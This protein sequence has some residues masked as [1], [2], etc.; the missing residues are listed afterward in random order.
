M[1]ANEGSEGSLSQ[2][3]RL[4]A[5]EPSVGRSGGAG[6]FDHRTQYPLRKPTKV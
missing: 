2:N 6:A 1:L 5:S 4:N 3:R